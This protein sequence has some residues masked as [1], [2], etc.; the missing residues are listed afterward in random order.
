MQVKWTKKNQ[1][2]LNIPCTKQKK[3]CM[4]IGREKKIPSSTIK[5]IKKKKRVG[6]KSQTAGVRDNY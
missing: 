6:G 2:I 1:Q 4:E 5:H 3:G